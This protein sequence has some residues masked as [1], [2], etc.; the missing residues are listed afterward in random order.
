MCVGD[1]QKIQ[2]LLPL[3]KKNKYSILSF[4]GECT[5]STKKF[6]ERITTRYGQK[7]E[8]TF[9][10]V[11]HLVE[12]NNLPKS[13]AQ[14][15]LIQRG[16]THTN[17]PGPLTKEVEKKVYVD[18][19]VEKKVYVDRA[20]EKVVYKDR[21]KIIDAPKETQ[22]THD[23]IIRNVEDKEK[24]EEEQNSLDN[25]NTGKWIAG[26]LAVGGVCYCVYR[27]IDLYF[28]K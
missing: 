25:S 27:I 12:K 2:N 28:G 18:R 13:T 7:D 24:L 14:L 15:L 26:S 17:N 21:P 8:S 22:R 11:M 1:T 3:D 4:G 16:L 20:V 5:M 10:N 9:R 6:D 23:E 19:P